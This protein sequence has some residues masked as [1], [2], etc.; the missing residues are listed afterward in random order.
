MQW[1]TDTYAGWGRALTATGELARPERSR[2]ITAEGP[3]IGNRRS[4]GDAPLNSDGKAT[5]MSRMNRIIGFEDGIVHVEAGVTLGE[6][7]R[8]YAKKGYM[9][10]VMPG[11]GFATVG[12]A[13]GMDVHGKN[14]HHAGSFGQHVTEI[15]LRTADGDKTITPA[16]D[17]LWRATIGGLGQTGVI[18]SAKLKLTPISG[19]QMQVTETRAANWEQ[20][21][22]RL[23]ASTAP[24]CVGWIDATAK[25]DA[26]GRGIIEEAEVT[27]GDYEAPKGGKKVPLDAPSFALSKPIVKLFNTAYY[28]RVPAEGRTV[29]RSFEQFFFPLDKVQDWNKLYG[30][31]GFHQFQCVVPTNQVDALKAMLNAIA[32]SGLASPL[33]V[34]KR[35]GPGRGGM[36]SFPMEGYTLA[37]DFPA[38]DAA[39]DLIKE[40][41]TLTAAAEGRIYFAKDSMATPAA[42]AGM[43]PEQT[44][45]ADAVNAADPD[46]TFATDLTRRLNLR[47]AK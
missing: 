28:N 4:Y 46:L 40:L 20:H 31:R 32:E 7:T 39:K 10:T 30:K 24:Y 3:A 25:G 19:G 35:M 38:R 37:V 14:H 12:G 29:N 2:N 13:I 42:I 11:T 17:T 34:L 16:D 5:D 36:M 45:W 23:D 47:G 9:P 15:T 21:I 1:K 41:I 27:S 26:M 43:Y 6:L 22:E 8:I 44:D 18:L 33:A